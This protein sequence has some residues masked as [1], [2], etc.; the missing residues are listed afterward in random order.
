MLVKLTYGVE[1]DNEGRFLLTLNKVDPEGVI[2]EAALDQLDSLSFSHTV[3]NQPGWQHR[4]VT[5]DPLWSLASSIKDLWKQIFYPLKQHVVAMLY[6]QIPKVLQDTLQFRPL[7]VYYAN[8]NVS[9]PEWVKIVRND[10]ALVSKYTFIDLNNGILTHDPHMV[11][12]ALNQIAYQE[13]MN[14]QKLEKYNTQSRMCH[15]YKQDAGALITA[16]KEVLHEFIMT[17]KYNKHIPDFFVVPAFHISRYYKAM[18][19]LLE[20]HEPVSF[21]MTLPMVH[22]EKHYTIM[23]PVLP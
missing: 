2:P 18:K 16:A 10:L 8:K 20:K 1:S 12:S 7:F 23:F 5:D 9:G 22:E 13:R 3:F 21:I 14:M 15:W 19:I 11:N 6:F 4:T 17:K